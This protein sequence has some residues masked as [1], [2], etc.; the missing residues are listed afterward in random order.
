MVER[1]G[2]TAQLG[3]KVHPHMLRYACGFALANK[4]HDSRALQAYLGHRNIQYTVRY[5]EAA[6]VITVTTRAALPRHKFLA[7]QLFRR[8]AMIFAIDV[9]RWELRRAVPA[10]APPSANYDWTGFYIGRRTWP[11][12]QTLN[13]SG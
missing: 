5:T 10:F 2:T 4:G 8:A 1:A 7:I 12:I 13:R 6:Q 11:L 9:P 3:F